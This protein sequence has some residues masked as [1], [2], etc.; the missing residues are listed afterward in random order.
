MGYKSFTRFIEKKREKHD[1][2]AQGRYTESTFVQL[3]KHKQWHVRSSSWDENVNSHIDYFLTKN[4]TTHAIDVKGMRA[5]SRMNAIIQDEWHI[6]EF[7]AVAYPTY[8]ASSF[9]LPFN[10]YEPDFS[11]G[12]GRR[13]W[14]YGQ[15]DFIAFETKFQWLFV[16]PVD[17]QFF[18]HQHIDANTVVMNAREAQYKLY[19]RPNRGDLMSLVH[20]DDIYDLAVCKWNKM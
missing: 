1:Q 9:S 8:L 19:S 7:I 13:G 12:S 2:A 14:L 3:A 11:R 17:L 6:V 20:R 4:D 10:I 15:S 5:L 16:R 18:C